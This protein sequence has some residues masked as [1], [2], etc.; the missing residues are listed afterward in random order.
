MVFQ[1]SV[2]QRQTVVAKEIENVKKLG[3]KIETNV[4][5]GKSM[6]IDELIE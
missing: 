1:N 5:I 6:T 3:V 2:F 4:V